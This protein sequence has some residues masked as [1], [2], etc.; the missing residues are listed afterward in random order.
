[1]PTER[2]EAMV[3]DL[4]AILEGL[5]KAKVRF[6]L[7]GGLAAVVQG[8]PIT[9][10]DVDILHDR[11]SENV[12]RLSKYLKSIGAIY[13]RPDDKVQEP[14][15]SDL[16]EMGHRLLTTRLGPLDALTFIED[17]KTYEDLFSNSVEIELR[18]HKIHVLDLRTMVELKKNSTDP[19]DRQRLPVLME[20]LRQSEE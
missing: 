2:R 19:G 18:G 8:A 7:V 16:A 9:T 5:A 12:A 1:M 3:P 17:G 4:S 15:A 6:I 20:T 13:R 10:M 11:S 14:R